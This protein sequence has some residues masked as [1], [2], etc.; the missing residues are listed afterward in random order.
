MTKRGVGGGGGGLQAG[1]TPPVISIPGDSS[2]AGYF[3]LVAVHG[4]GGRF[5]DTIGTKGVD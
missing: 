2:Q 3:F 5:R 4:K 1:P